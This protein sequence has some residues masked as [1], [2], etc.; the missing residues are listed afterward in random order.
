MEFIDFKGIVEW[1]LEVKE[2]YGITLVFILANILWAI[3]HN[4]TFTGFYKGLW[5]RITAEEKNGYYKKVLEELKSSMNEE[6]DICNNKM[7]ELSQIIEKQ[8]EQI[9]LLREKEMALSIEIATLKE[10]LDLAQKVAAKHLPT[11]RGRKKTNP[12]DN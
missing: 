11:S 3:L 4:K 2:N 9:D 12:N 6:R 1:F 8:Q 7:T 5:N 10:R